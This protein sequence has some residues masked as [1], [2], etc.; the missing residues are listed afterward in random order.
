M[1]A[2]DR[3]G[4][5]LGPSRFVS[6]GSGRTFE[7]DDLTLAEDL[8]H[9]AARPGHRQRPPL[10][11]SA[12]VARTL[13]E[14]MLPPQLPEIPG[15]PAGRP[16]SAAEGAEVGGDFYDHFELGEGRWGDRGRRSMQQRRPGGR[17]DRP[18]PPHHPCPG[19]AGGAVLGVAGRQRH[20]PAAEERRVPHLGLCRGGEPRGRNPRSGVRGRSSSAPPRTSR[21]D[22]WSGSGAP[23]PGW[24]C[25]P[26]RRWERRGAAR[27][28]ESLVLYT[29]ELIEEQGPAW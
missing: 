17:P 1:R 25:S 6:A 12:R 22:G 11:N 27:T 28:R 8:A 3:S 7:E 26:T 2:V 9:R 21:K 14:G 20:D 10:R 5:L 23:A 4:A 13:Q 29:D 18:G 24:G 15:I 19:A 16:L